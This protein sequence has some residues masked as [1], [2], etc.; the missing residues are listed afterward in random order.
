VLTA[1]LLV[2][3]AACATT[4]RVTAVWMNQR[5]QVVPAADESLFLRDNATMLQTTGKFLPASQ[6][7]QEFYVSWCGTGAD[8]V[9]FEYR[10]VYRF[11]T[12]L[13]KTFVPD[14]RRFNTIFSVTGDEY[15]QGGTVSAWRVSLWHNGQMLADKQSSLW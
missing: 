5:L 7:G 1:S 4:P 10:Q 6:Q 12:V 15:S 2:L 13:S 9:K 11:D 3:A 14:G 8:L